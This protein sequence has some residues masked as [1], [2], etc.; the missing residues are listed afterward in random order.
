[1]V[2]LAVDTSGKNGS[3]ALVR[4]EGEIGR[5]LELLLL[6]GGAFSAQLIPQIS[7]L[8]VKQSLSKHQIDGFA[9]VSGPGSFTG[10]RVG[11]AAIKASAEILQKPI[12]AVSLLEVVARAAGTRGR[13]IAVLDAG[14]KDVYVGVYEFEA[15]QACDPI[16]ELL[17]IAELRAKVADRAVITPDQTLADR[18]EADGL[19]VTLIPHP[20]AD[21]VAGLGFEK[22]RNGEVVSP[23]A[24]DATYIRRTDAEIMQSRKIFR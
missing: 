20:R 15:D 4:F 16:E 14:R 8:L 17:T 1:M 19:K 9:V 23:E 18:L 7:A 12:A 5:T 21:A 11:L 3:L 24:L 22:I 2:I 10:L 13:M 6:E